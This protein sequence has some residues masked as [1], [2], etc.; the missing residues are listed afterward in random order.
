MKV[1]TGRRR[2]VTKCKWCGDSPTNVD[3]DTGKCWDCEDR[4]PQLTLW[5]RRGK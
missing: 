1:R 2:F 5:E 3:A 4:L